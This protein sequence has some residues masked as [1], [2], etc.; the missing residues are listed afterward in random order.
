MKKHIVVSLFLAIL[1]VACGQGKPSPAAVLT[2]AI[3]TLSTTLTPFSPLDPTPTI[4]PTL[5]PTNTSTP[6][7]TATPFPVMGPD[8]FPANVDPLTGLVVKNPKILDRRPVAF[9]VN[10]TNRYSDRPPYGLSFA[11]IV[12]DF[13]HNGGVSRYHA[14]FYGEDAEL[15]GPIRSARMLDNILVPAYKSLFAFGHV[16]YELRSLFDNSSYSDRLLEEGQTKTCPPTTEV[17]LCRFDPN[18]SD[19]LLGGTKEISQHF[20]D[21]GIDNERQDLNGMTFHAIVPQGGKT[22]EQLFVRYSFANYK[23]WDFD[24]KTGRYMLFVDK[25]NDTGGSGEEYEPLSDRLT[26]KQIGAD[27]VVV[28]VVDDEYA[29]RPPNEIVDINLLGTG[30]AYAFRDGKVYQV[31]WNH[32]DKDSVVYLTDANG[33]DFPLKPGKTW[34]EITNPIGQVEHQADSSW[35]FTY[36]ILP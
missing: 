13:Y 5:I 1:L 15:V 33:K 17:P 6:A 4:L 3:P 12:F 28:L 26:E 32:P 21:K 14:I 20:T 27:N 8:H 9:K 23:R 30:T 18:G 19:L 34:F 25:I 16:T 29:Q 11:D 10:V 22:G 7:P 24:S 36:K 2:Q 31:T 35:R